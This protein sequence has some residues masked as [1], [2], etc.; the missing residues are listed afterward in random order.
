MDSSSSSVLSVNISTMNGGVQSGNDVTFSMFSS[1]KSLFVLKIIPQ[2]GL[3]SAIMDTALSVLPQ[4]RLTKGRELREPWLHIREAT[5]NTVKY[6][7]T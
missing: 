1:E 2:I 5:V 4:K 7:H 3:G 6:I